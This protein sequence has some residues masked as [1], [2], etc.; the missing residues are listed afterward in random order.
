YRALFSHARA[1]WRR[2]W[3]QDRAQA[4]RLVCQGPAR[5]RRVSQSGELRGR[6]AR[7]SRRTG[8]LLRAVPAPAGRVNDGIAGP[9]EPRELVAGLTFALLVLRPDLTIEQVNPAAENMIGRSARKLV[10]R[11]FLEVVGFSESRVRDKLFA[12][13]AQLVARGLAIV[14]DGRSLLANLTISPL[15]AHPGWRAVTLSDAGQGE[16]IA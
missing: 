13:E 16:R 10:G 12:E 3:R 15:A 2:G 6:S 9:P 5:V 7:S 8:T 4:P 11:N 14:V 1:L